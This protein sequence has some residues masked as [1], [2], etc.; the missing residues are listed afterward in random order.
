LLPKALLIA[1]SGYIAKLASAYGFKRSTVVPLASDYKDG[2]APTR[3]NS[4]IFFAGR[5]A[6]RKGLSHFVRHVLP[7]L[8]DHIRLRVAGPVWE[9]EEAQVLA[10]PRVDY[11][12]ILPPEELQRE[13]ASALC[14]IVPS[15]EPEGFGLVAAEAASAGGVVLA[16]AHS[17]LVEAVEAGG[18]ILLDVHEPEQWARKILHVL[19]WSAEERTRFTS[20]AMARGRSFFSWERVARQTIEGYER[21]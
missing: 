10:C 8:P 1:N 13:Y 5:I 17:G 14:V 19:K 6:R 11:V 18:G 2:P 15:L 3:H 12:G 4:A 7:L 16:A 9:Q 20:T 21:A